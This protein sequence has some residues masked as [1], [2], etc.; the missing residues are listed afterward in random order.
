MGLQSFLL[1]FGPAMLMDPLDP[2][3]LDLARYVGRR[4]KI[5]TLR[6]IHSERSGVWDRGAVLMAYFFAAF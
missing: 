3:Q 4:G 1:D 5:T 6:P 2:I